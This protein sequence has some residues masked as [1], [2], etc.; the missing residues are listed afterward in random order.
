MDITDLLQN[1]VF[2][3]IIIGGA[4]LVFG[5]I[6]IL[7][8]IVT[9]AIRTRKSAS[10]SVEVGKYSKQSISGSESIGSIGMRLGEDVRDVWEMG[11]S[12]D[13]INGVLTEKYTLAEMYKMGPEGNSMSAKGKEILV[14]KQK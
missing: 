5:V 11:Y 9:A 4:F 10:T 7:F 13:Q 3:K 14:G 1:P 6:Y 2:V 8:R 12:N